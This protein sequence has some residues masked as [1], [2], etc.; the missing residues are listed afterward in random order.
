MVRFIR[1][2]I[3]L[4]MVP[5]CMAATLALADLLRG[6]PLTPQLV[7]PQTLALAGGYFVW[8]ALYLTVLRPTR[9]YIWAHELTHALWGLLCGAKIHAIEVGEGGGAVSLSKTNV[10]IALAPYFFPFYTLLVILLRIVVGFWIP[11]EPWQL[12]WL[13]LVGFTW[14]FHFTFTAQTLLMRQPDIVENGR[15]FSLSL[16]YLLNIAGIGLWVVCTTPATAGA[17]GHHLAIRSAAV[18]AWAWREACGL[19]AAV[20]AAF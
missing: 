4:L 18:Y 10:L 15:V 6:L 19:V 3:G 16:I 5:L 8:L 13:F 9:A 2:L 11:M 12:V 17:L 14:G 1:F 7:P 20:R